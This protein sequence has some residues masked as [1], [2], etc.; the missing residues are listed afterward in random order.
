MDFQTEGNSIVYKNADGAV[1]AHVDFSEVMS[2]VYDIFHTEVDASLQGQGI[3]GKLVAR[4]VSEI[5][6]RDGKLLKDA[7]CSYAAAWLK[8]HAEKGVSQ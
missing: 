4:A 2:G 1:L 5:E 6:R 3:A 7:S 8:R